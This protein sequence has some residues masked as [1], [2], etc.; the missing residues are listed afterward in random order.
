MIGFD[1]YRFDCSHVTSVKSANRDK[2]P[3]L[4]DH[5]LKPDELLLATVIA[6]A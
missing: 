1:L 5:H 2:F 3:D 4:F 6:V